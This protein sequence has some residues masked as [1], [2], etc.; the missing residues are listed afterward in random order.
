MPAIPDTRFGHL[1]RVLVYDQGGGD[2]IVNDW[3]WGHYSI[4]AEEWEVRGDESLS[5]TSAGEPHLDFL[6]GVGLTCKPFVNV[7]D[8]RSANYTTSG[9]SWAEL[10]TATFGGLAYRLIQTNTAANLAWSVTSGF[11]LPGNPHV[12][13]E[14]H[15]SETPPDNT[16]ATFPPFVRI[17]FGEAW[18]IE[19][20]RVYGA[21]LLRYVSGAFRAVKVLSG[22]LPD[23][24]MVLLRWHRGSIFIST[25]WGQSYDSFGLPDGADATVNST[26]FT[27]RGQGGAVMVGLHQV[28]YTE[29]T[30]TTTERSTLTSRSSSPL[31]S[32]RFYEPTGTNVAV[33]YTGSGSTA[34]Y[35]ATLTPAAIAGVPFTFYTSPE[36]YSV[37]TS[38]PSVRWSLPTGFYSEPF[39]GTLQEI[40]VDKPP[41]LHGG[42][43]TITFRKDAA[44]QFSGNWRWTKCE[45]WLADQSGSGASAF[46]RVFVGYV[47]DPDIAQ[48][49]YNK[50]FG[51][52]A[53]QNA[54]IRAKRMK[55]DGFHLPLGGQSL[56]SALDYCLDKMGLTVAD[57][58]WHPLGNVILVPAGMAED[59]AY[60]APAGEEI[61]RIMEE[62]CRD[63]G[64]ELGVDD[65]GIWRTVRMDAYDDFVSHSWDALAATD[66]AYRISGISFTS[67][68]AEACTSILLKSK[69]QYGR[70]LWAYG[71]DTE[72]EFNPT[73]P[74]YCPWRELHYEEV[75]GT[76]SPGWLALGVQSR[77]FSHV[78]PK[79]E[80]DLAI[81]V[82][83]S[84]HR[85][86]VGE[87]Q[88]TYVG[89][90][91][92]D[93]FWVVALQHRWSANYPQ[94]ETVAYLR[95]IL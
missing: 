32:G 43:A 38:F 27:V 93:K 67:R 55:W 68:A 45:V 87:V 13:F 12:A 35:R 9:G 57:R 84:A 66:H 36:L 95:R 89:I 70:P 22:G 10:R 4:L 58:V 11:S 56:N 37:S 24:V 54:T 64:F 71:V 83:S 59:P 8:T 91:N 92:F 74:R 17:E 60:W 14:I 29:G 63:A 40:S 47:E 65:A 85:R 21:R 62:V 90:A 51:T 75:D 2:P 50:S 73:S 26:P 31:M 94:S 79:Y 33:T 81:P 5:A 34:Q 1:A 78:L 52:I 61:W 18:A 30:F 48:A 15:F 28:L 42:T 7:K 41:E 25:D 72:A 86:Q 3:G 44:T 82:T 6:D 53:L 39:E 69:D 49:E 77:F 80:A 88:N 20:S 46:T 23:S 16:L 19:F 76:V